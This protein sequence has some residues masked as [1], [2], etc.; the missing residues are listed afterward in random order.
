M[1]ICRRGIH[2]KSYFFMDYGFR[3][4]LVQIS[5][6]V[7]FSGVGIFAMVKTFWKSDVEQ[8]DDGQEKIRRSHY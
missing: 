7:H 3:E 2:V 5:K 8:F 4:K 6:L 1:D